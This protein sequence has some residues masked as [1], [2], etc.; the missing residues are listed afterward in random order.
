MRR[1]LDLGA[2]LTDRHPKAP[3]AHLVFL[4]VRPDRQGRGLGSAILKRTLAD[5][6]AQRLGAYLETAAESNVRLYQR[7]GFEVSATLR[8]P[9]DGPTFWTMWRPARD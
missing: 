9:P 7:F 6:D 3:H 4:G 8:C 2:L 1:A 5:V